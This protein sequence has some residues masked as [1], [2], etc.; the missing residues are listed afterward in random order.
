MKV[1]SWN[2]LASEWIDNKTYRNIKKEIRNNN[3][4]RFE[5]IIK[6]ITPQNASVIVLQEVMPNEYKHL[7]LLFQE[8]YIITPLYSITWNKNKNKNKSG[9]VTLFKRSEFSVKYMKHVRLS[10]GIQTTCQY[11]NKLC[12]IYNVHLSDSSPQERYL[13]MNSIMKTLLDAEMCMICGDFNHQY[14]KCSAFYNLPNYTVHN[15]TCKTYYLDR[16]TNID[17][18]LSKGFNRFTTIVCP[19]C[20]ESDE[21]GMLQYG[22][23]H[24]PI[25]LVIE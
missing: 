23:D 2:I 17:N 8:N 18:I 10:F 19:K 5:R 1:L 13:Q 14:M 11:K 15:T 21:E 22:S 3:K 12:M 24:L 6:Y 4:F 9:N 16:R 7:K 20:P 25:S